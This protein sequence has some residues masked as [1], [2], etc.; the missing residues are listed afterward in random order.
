[1]QYSVPEG[2]YAACEDSVLC[3]YIK[4]YLSLSLLLS[5]CLSVF[6]VVVIFYCGLIK[7]NVF[8]HHG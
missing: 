6:F 8:R 5:V 1:M 4:H 7:I 3:I 2:L